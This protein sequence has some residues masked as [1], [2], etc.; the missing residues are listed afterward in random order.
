MMTTDRELDPLELGV[1]AFERHEMD[2]ARSYFRQAVHKDAG[3][4]RAWSWLA[5]TAQTPYEKEYYLRRIL[6]INPCDRT[7]ATLLEQID[8]TSEGEPA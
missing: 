4:E 7:A 1:R 2:K 8:G 6:D 5:K 3:N